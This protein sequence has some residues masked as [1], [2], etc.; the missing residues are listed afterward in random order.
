MDTAMDELALAAPTWE[1]F[2]VGWDMGLYG[3][4]ILCAVLAGV[5]LGYLGVF[6]VL[7]RMVFITAAVSQAAGL[8]VALSFWVGIHFGTEVS[9]VFGALALAL[10]VTGVVSLPAERLRLSQE[11][12]LGVAY[13]ACWAGAV[14]VGDRIVQEAHDIA[15]IL[16]GTAVLVRDEDVL[17]V[18]GASALVL[19]VH[20]VGNRGFVFAAFDPTSARVQGLPV[21]ALD[22][23]SWVLIAIMVSVATR[24]L[25]VLPVFAFAV[26]PAMAALALVDRLRWALPLA[27]LLGGVAGGAGYLF[28]F[29]YEFPVGASQA[30]VAFALF[31]LALPLRLARRGRLA[32]AR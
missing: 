3:P 4:P 7:R 5:A 28:A 1:D 32:V 20:L 10:V 13:L 8:G 14:L 25:G 2:L 24:A 18:G 15:S 16:F 27:A 30:S 31:V 26:M 11:S 9:P 6:V 22:L 17:L 21:R 12:L 29:F 23:T 19:L